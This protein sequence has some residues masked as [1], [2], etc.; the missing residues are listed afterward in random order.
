MQNSDTQHIPKSVL[1]YAFQVR[2][3]TYSRTSP[4]VAHGCSLD[5]WRPILEA[6][7]NSIASQ[8]VKLSCRN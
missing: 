8:R 1:H 2:G 3:D 6:L 5:S 4:R 7:S